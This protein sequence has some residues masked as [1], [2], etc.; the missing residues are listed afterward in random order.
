MKP[1]W[2]IQRGDGPVVA[3]ALHHGH[4]LRPEVAECIALDDET[5]RREEDPFTERFTEVAETRVVVDR[6]RFEADLNRPNEDTVCTRPDVCWDLDVWGGP[7]PDEIVYGSQALHESFY[8]ELHELLSEVESRYGNFVVLDLH[9]Y[10][11]R[12]GGPDAPP[13][14]PAGNPDVNIGT[15]S[16]NRDRWGPLVDRFMSEL[17]EA[18]D[19]DVRENVKFYGRYLASFVHENF[20]ETGCCPAIE[21]KKTFLDEWTN[22]LDEKRLTHLVTALRSTIH[23]L[24]TSLKE[25]S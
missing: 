4:D 21:F 6:S 25:L 19:I 20:P 13:D 1:A 22:E 2:R 24:E 16:M 17:A 15:R 23:G 5:R 7:V 11:H 12:R 10:N 9:A 14:D 3:V 8:D 18:G